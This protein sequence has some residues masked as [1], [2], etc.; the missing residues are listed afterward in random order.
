MQMNRN[1]ADR[2]A[3]CSRSGFSLVELMVVFVLIGFIVG[4]QGSLSSVDAG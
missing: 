4:I 2:T 1:R 3:L